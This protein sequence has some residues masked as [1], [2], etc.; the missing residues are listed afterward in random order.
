[1]N[2][3]TPRQKPPAA[4][5]GGA[6]AYRRELEGGGRVYVD[7]PLPFL[8]LNRTDPDAPASLAHRVATITASNVVWPARAQADAAAHSAILATT[9]KDAERLPAGTAYVLQQT[10]TA[11]PLASLLSPRR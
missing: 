9:A 6:T 2:A 8:V 7:R 11:P 10:L 5:V 4:D 3:P 1:M